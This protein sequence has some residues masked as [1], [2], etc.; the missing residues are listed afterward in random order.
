MT[1]HSRDR[2]KQMKL[3]TT[4]TCLALAVASPAFAQ[5]SLGVVDPFDTSIRDITE[6]DEDP[7]AYLSEDFAKGREK[8][9][10]FEFS[11]ESM[12]FDTVRGETKSKTVRIVNIG[13]Q[14]GDI[15]TPILLSGNGVFTLDARCEPFLQPGEFCD[16]TVTAS[17]A[18]SGTF[19]TGMV[20][21]VEERERSSVSIDIRLKVSDPIIP[22]G[23][24]V[25]EEEL[26]RK[27]QVALASSYINNSMLPAPIIHKRGFNQISAPRPVQE[28]TVGVPNSQ[29]RAEIVRTQD[30]YSEDVATVEA[31]LPVDQSMILTTDRVIKAVL[32]TPISNVACGKVVALVESDVYG[33]AGQKPLIDSGSR[34]V[35]KCGAF[36]GARAAVSW[37]RIITR[38]G[39]SIE[40]DANKT[41]TRDANG[42]GGVP[43][44]IYRSNFDTFVLPAIS[45]MIGIIPGVAM[46]VWG[47]QEEVVTDS[48]GNTF[49]STSARNEGIRQIGEVASGQTQS[50]IQTIADPREVVVIP[51]GSRID[52]EIGE[53]VVFV[54]EKRIV[55]VAE[56]TYDVDRAPRAKVIQEENPP[57]ILVP[58]RDGVEGPRVNIGGQTYVLKPASE[59]FESTKA[60]SIPSLPTDPAD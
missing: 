33:G 44:R 16:V 38:D 26:R 59:N 30:R 39:R 3:A 22:N 29:V 48:S 58:Y 37:E 25:S 32:E 35:G 20:V 10:V 19:A 45:T 54:G 11:S 36:L 57:M 41:E 15:K 17:S 27:R 60:P 7:F 6:L 56:M 4:F 51:A 1:E 49:A 55:R 8:G 23:P 13:D 34:I 5:Q 40:I 46:S 50:A 14:P 9:P 47:E 24:A 18:D 2:I 21:S 28:V 42:L 53:D 31:S 12:I 52:V 43:G